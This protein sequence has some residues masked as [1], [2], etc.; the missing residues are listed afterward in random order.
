[1]GGSWFVVSYVDCVGFSVLLDEFFLLWG[2]FGCEFVLFCFGSCVEDCSSFP[3]ESATG[4]VGV[5]SAV[6]GC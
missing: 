4:F 5:E 6:F 1:M 2:C 3:L